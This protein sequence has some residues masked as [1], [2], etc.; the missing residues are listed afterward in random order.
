M[1]DCILKLFSWSLLFL[2]FNSLAASIAMPGIQW[3]LFPWVLKW[4][5][6]LFPF[7]SSSQIFLYACLTKRLSKV[8]LQS[9][10][11]SAFQVHLTWKTSHYNSS[12]SFHTGKKGSCF[13]LSCGKHTHVLSSC[14]QPLIHRKQT[15]QATHWSFFSS[16]LKYS[17]PKHI[18][19]V[20]QS[21]GTCGLILREKCIISYII[22]SGRLR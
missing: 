5:S 14:A 20:Q 7:N 22:Y 18:F 3:T 6:C 16:C 9:L 10:I 21:P 1:E 13:K 11:K 4:R 19:W 12:D 8:N 15:V 2:S 17:T